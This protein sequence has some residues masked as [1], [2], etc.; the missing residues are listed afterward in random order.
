A[1]GVSGT[2]TL[3]GG[4]LILSPPPGQI[5]D[6]NLEVGINGTGFFLQTAGSVTASSLD[7]GVG[8]GGNGTYKLGGAGS[9]AVGRLEVIGGA[10]LAQAEF[11]QTGGTHT[12]AG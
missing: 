2:Y 7:L 5:Q 11:D 9:L 4:S 10:A 1:G 6:G 3:S 12:V 8:P